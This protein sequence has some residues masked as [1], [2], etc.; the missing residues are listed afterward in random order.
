[1]M[2]QQTK[3]IRKVGRCE[4]CCPDGGAIFTAEFRDGSDVWV[5]NNC[6]A[7]VPR[8]RLIRRQPG[9]ERATR[10]QTQAIDRIRTWFGADFTVEWIGRKAWITA[11]NESRSPYAG[12]LL[13]GSIG[14]TGRMELVLY[15]LGGDRAI[16]CLD[17]LRGEA[18]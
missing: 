9:S 3:T 12:N 5:C 17:D 18:W 8:R 10:S 16:R 2:A 11:R 7:I 4:R 13:S 15:R 1:M 14:P 6:M